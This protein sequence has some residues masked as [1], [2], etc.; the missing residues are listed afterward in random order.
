MGRPRLPLDPTRRYK[1][2]H[3]GVRVPP[4]I[5]RALEEAAKANQCYMTDVVLLFLQQRLVAEGFMEASDE[6]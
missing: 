1:K 2:M 5:R 4:K 6:Q 3:L